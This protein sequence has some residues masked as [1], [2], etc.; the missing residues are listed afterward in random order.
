MVVQSN[1]TYPIQQSLS[2]IKS[3]IYSF[4]LS[5]HAE[6]LAKN[7]IKKINKVED[8]KIEAKRHWIGTLYKKENRHL[9]ALPL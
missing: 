4:L 9:L 3:R 2:R 7:R 6:R 5:L 8:E 1:R